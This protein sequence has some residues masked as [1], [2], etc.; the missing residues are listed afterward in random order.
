VTSRPRRVALPGLGR[1]AGPFLATLGARAARAVI[2]SPLPSASARKRCYRIDLADGRTVKLRRSTSAREAR[3]YAE[4]VDA[5]GE[6]RLARVLARRGDLTLEEWVPGTSLDALAGLTRRQHAAGGDFLGTL[7]AVRRLGGVALPRAV[8]TRTVRR[9]LLSDLRAVLAIGAISPDV[10]ARLR[11]A[12]ERHD[13]GIARAGVLHLDLC[14]ENLVRGPGGLIRAVDN[15]GMRIGPTGFDLARAW[16][17]WPMRP[18]AWRG[19][20]AAYARHADAAPA[21]AHFP[22]WQIA[23][24]LQSARL[25]LTRG[26]PHAEIPVRALAALAATFEARGSSPGGASRI[27]G[28]SVRAPT[29][30]RRTR[31]GGAARP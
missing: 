19:F 7:H 3:Q 6:P 2:I 9:R 31:A 25:R 10:G 14:P 1:A 16:Y 4:L 26:T 23:A 29:P 20:L 13:P 27:R 28:V 12:A 22:F 21:L 18:A 15:E 30:R 5:L 11:A 24:V 17:R 8:S